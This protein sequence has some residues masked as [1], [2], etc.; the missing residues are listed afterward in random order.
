MKKLFIPPVLVLFSLILIITFYFLIPNFNLIPYPYNLFGILLILLGFAIIG[1]TNELFLKHKT[2]RTINK[3]S[4]LLTEG[5]FSKSR[6]PMYT[7]MFLF[8]IGTGV[9]FMNLFSMLIPFVFILF[10]QLVFI[11][12]E[13]KLMTETFGEAYLDYKKKVRRWI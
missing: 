2:T 10:I 12:K 11:P 4:H 8:L 1:K 7:G 9:C 13:E 3:S 5:T 6:N